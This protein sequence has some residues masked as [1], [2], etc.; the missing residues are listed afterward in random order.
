MVKEQRDYYTN[1]TLMAIAKQEVKDTF[2]IN[3]DCFDEVYLRNQNE[4][5]VQLN[6]KPNIISGDCSSVPGKNCKL[7][8]IYSPNGTCIQCWDC[9]ARLPVP[10]NK[11]F[12]NPEAINEQFLN[13]GI[14]I[15]N[16]KT[17]NEAPLVVN[18][19]YMI[20]PMVKKIFPYRPEPDIFYKNFERLLLTHSHDHII[21]CLPYTCKF[22]YYEN[23]NVWYNGDEK[24]DEEK[25][26][27][28]IDDYYIDLLIN[29]LANYYRKDENKHVPL[30]N[31]KCYN[32]HIILNLTELYRLIN[33][34]KKELIELLKKQ[35]KADKDL[36]KPK[37]TKNDLFF[38]HM[39]PNKK[40]VYMTL[41]DMVIDYKRWIKFQG[42]NFIDKVLDRKELCSAMEEYLEKN[43]HNF[44]Y[45]KYKCYMINKHR[46]YCFRGV[47]FV[48]HTFLENKQ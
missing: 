39:I 21:K 38:G 47:S 45:T 32:K 33:A 7:R 23:D 48:F 25:V 28:I 15:N 12:L 46:I 42:D 34:S 19:T 2:G 44:V 10:L 37:Q 26:F 40:K 30:I 8:C 36:P 16:Y 13:I 1:R 3:D 41:D 43:K 24:I 6:E 18:E 11:Y 35:V 29:R 17:I 14:Q 4:L 20:Y 9:G 27:T 5:V 31:G 22:K